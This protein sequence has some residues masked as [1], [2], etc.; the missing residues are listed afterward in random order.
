MI[1]S[2]TVILAPGTLRGRKLIERTEN[3]Y[4]NKAQAQK[5]A[6]LYAARVELFAGLAAVSAGRRMFDMRRSA[7]YYV[8]VPGDNSLAR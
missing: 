6:G 7:L 3:V 5:V 4:E 2:S 8:F 1:V